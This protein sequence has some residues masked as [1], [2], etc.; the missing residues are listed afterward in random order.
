[1]FHQLCWVGEFVGG[2]REN[3][4]HSAP[5]SPSRNSLLQSSVIRVDS[6]TARATSAT[7]G[8]WR[9]RFEKT[10]TGGAFN[11]AAFRNG[12]SPFPLFLPARRR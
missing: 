9:L 5:S 2:C 10:R 3:V 4:K 6:H 7:D 12:V 8:G 11:L 1:S